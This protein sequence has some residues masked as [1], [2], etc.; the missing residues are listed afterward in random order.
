MITP[1]LPGRADIT[2]VMITVDRSPKRNYLQDTISNLRWGGVFQSERL[3][4][5]TLV[6]GQPIQRGVVDD[7]PSRDYDGVISDMGMRYSINAITADHRLLPCEN[8]GRALILGS[9][10]AS[11]HPQGWVLFLEDD[12][13]CCADFLG[14][15]GRWLDKYGTEFGNL[16]HNSSALYS[17]GCAYPQI[18]YA[19]GDIWQHRPFTFYGTQAIALRPNFAQALGAMISSNPKIEHHDPTESNRL[20]SP[21]EYDLMISHCAGFGHHSISASIPSFVQHIGMESSL[22]DRSPCHTF[23]SWPGREWSYR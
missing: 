18:S 7:D 16:F 5:F 14:S 23:P 10:L 12:I 22:S 11:A 9:K 1:E 4:S 17:F 8:A 2:V 13:D 3:R 20:L 15:V 6:V 19:S 21:A